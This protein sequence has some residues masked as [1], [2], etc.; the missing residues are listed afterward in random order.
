MLHA[1]EFSSVNATHA[2]DP[3]H[4]GA[5]KLISHLRNAR[6][7]INANGLSVHG[8]VLH[9]IIESIDLDDIDELAARLERYRFAL[10]DQHAAP[11]RLAEDPIS[12]EE[13]QV[14]KE[15]VSPC[16]SRWSPDN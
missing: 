1:A 16:R 14:G 4:P 6:G 11:A 13:R 7:R 3:L 5:G 10:P 12:S 9:R 2:N 15:C 8:D